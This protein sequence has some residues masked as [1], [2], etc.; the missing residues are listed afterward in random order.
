MGHD[1]EYPGTED[2][3][4]WDALYRSRG[5]EVAAHRPVFTG[6]V[7]SKIEVQVQSPGE[8]KRKSVIILQHPCALR[9][10]GVELHP[11]LLVAEIR[12]HPLIPV[13][14]WSRHISKMPLAD[15]VPTV[16]SGKRHQAAF[17]DEL[18]LVGPDQLD[19][20]QR[21]ACLSHLGVNLL[22]QRWVHHS[23]RVVVP[24]ATYLEVSS[25]A[26]EEADLIE[27]WC[28][29]RVE[30]GLTV[31]EA[32]DEA[33]KWLREDLGTGI[34]RQQMLEDPQNRSAVRQQQRA[35]LRELR[36]RAATT[37]Q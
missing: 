6:D 25:P 7:F 21:V 16:T 5:D 10:N 1:L 33:L 26:Y 27:D 13:E 4:D 8:T 19:L 9:T 29:D 3:P 37:S 22:F 17:F 23:S 24:A 30:A 32:T 36:Q 35:A 14:H 31:R 12:T 15:L 28:E 34:T 2:V 18:Y 11:R 20:Q